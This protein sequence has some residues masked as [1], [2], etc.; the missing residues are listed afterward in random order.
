MS[1]ESKY[2]FVVGLPRTGTKLVRNILQNSVNPS[3]VISPETWFFGDMFRSGVRK[4]IHAIGDMNDEANVYTLIDYLYSGDFKRTYWILLNDNEFDITRAQLT[5]LIVES[6]RT[7]RSIYQA[8]MQATA[9]FHHNKTGDIILGDKTPGH[10]Y[11]VETLLR[12]FPEAKIIH[13]F[14]DPRAIV[15]SEWKRLVEERPDTLK[16]RFLNPIYSIVVVLYVTITWLY[17]SRLHNK[18]IKKYPSNYFMSKYEDLVSSP[19]DNT[20]V[21]CNFANIDFNENM[22]QPKK[23]NSSFVEQKGS[24]FDVTG[25]NRWDAYLKPWIKAWFRFFCKKQINDFNYKL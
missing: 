14:R 1:A 4:K 9:Q 16:N 19:V 8:I 23:V 13:T 7:D 3:C 6:D 25:L 15:A 24:G 10:L 22:L 18:Y 21:L 2:I 17:A 11:Y 20:K 5:S 12:W